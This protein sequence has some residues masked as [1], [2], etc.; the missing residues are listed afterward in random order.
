[1]KA[2]DRSGAARVALHAADLGFVHPKTGDE[3]HFESRLP[4]DIVA[5]ITRLRT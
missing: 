1:V 3:L 2:V 5:L 4:P